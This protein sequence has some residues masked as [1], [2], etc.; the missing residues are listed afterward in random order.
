MPLTQYGKVKVE[1]MQKELSK[2]DIKGCF[3]LADFLLVEL[4][5]PL[6]VILSTKI[7]QSFYHYRILSYRD[8][9]YGRSQSSQKYH[10]AI[11][12][13][14]RPVLIPQAGGGSS[15]YSTKTINNADGPDCYENQINTHPLI[16]HST[17]GEQQADEAQPGNT[18][19]ILW[20]L[21][22]S[23]CIIL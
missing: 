14:I 16:Y 17:V 10:L 6:S 4:K 18:V 3:P 2:T 20:L 13:Y 8:P 9:Y 15:H 23:V 11:Q 5:F 7:S 12:I 19:P 21:H 22:V 1:R